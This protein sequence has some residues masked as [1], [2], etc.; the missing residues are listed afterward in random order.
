[1]ARISFEDALR[2]G[3]DR[4]IFI[5][6]QEERAARRRPARTKTQPTGT[7]FAIRNKRLTIR[8]GA[9]RLVYVVIT[10]RKTTTGETRKYIVSPYEFK[11]RR[12]KIGVRKMLY[13]YDK[14]D[15]HIKSFALRNIRRVALTDTKYR[16]KWPVK[17][18]IWIFGIGLL[19]L[20]AMS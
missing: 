9:L 14:D 20:A 2:K 5:E 17:I 19:Q 11:Y 15:K 4:A 6:E 1:M 18:T 12:L 3:I 8:E 10:Y 16:P 7:L 13:A